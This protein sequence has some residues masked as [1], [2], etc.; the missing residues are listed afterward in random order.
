MMGLLTGLLTFPLAPLRGTVAVAEQVLKQAEEVYYDPA[1]IRRELEEVER[2]R[3][4]GEI[5]DEEATA[6]EDQLIERLIEGRSRSEE[7]P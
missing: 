3:E 5:D 4:A 7:R 1:T 2:L 6:W